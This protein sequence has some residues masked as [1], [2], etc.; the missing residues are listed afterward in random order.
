MNRYRLWGPGLVWRYDTGRELGLDHIRG[1]PDTASQE[2]ED[3]G[4][5]QGAKLIINAH[6][7]CSGLKGDGRVADIGSGFVLCAH[8]ASDGVCRLALHVECH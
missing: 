6:G 5:R 3:I 7:C 1:G 4:G 2:F 8:D